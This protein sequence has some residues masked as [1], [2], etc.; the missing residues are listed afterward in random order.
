MNKLDIGM[1]FINPWNHGKWHDEVAYYG[2]CNQA[3][4]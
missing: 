2:P 3:I 4:Y 1:K